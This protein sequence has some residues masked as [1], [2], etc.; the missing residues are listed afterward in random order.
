MPNNKSILLLQDP[1][2]TFFKSLYKEFK[3]MGCGIYH[4]NLGPGDYFYWM[5]Y[6]NTINYKGS[7]QKWSG[8]LESFI[9]KNKITDVIYF[10]DRFPYHSLARDVTEKLGVNAY[11]CESGY[12]RPDWITLERKGMSALSYF[13]SDPEVIIQKAKGLPSI[14]QELKYPHS[15]FI[16]AWHAVTF[17]LLNIFFFW[18]FPKYSQYNYY[19]PIAEYLHMLPRLLRKKKNNIRSNRKLKILIE[20]KEKYYLFP[21]QLQ[22]DSQIH[23]NS[24]FAHI[25]DAIDLAINSFSRNELCDAKLVFKTHPMD[26][27]IEKWHKII[28]DIAKK[29]SILDKIDILDGGDL[30]QMIL[31]A[32]G[33]LTVN[34]T[35]GI[36]ALRLACPTKVLGLSIYDIEGLTYQGHLDDFW[37]H[38]E[39]PDGDLY[40]AFEKLLINY[41]QCKGNLH[42]KVG[43]KLASKKIV[44]RVL[45]GDSNDFDFQPRIKQAKKMGVPINY[46]EEFLLSVSKNLWRSVYKSSI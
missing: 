32:L 12:L 27:G 33:V 7:L 39:K 3:S 19:C 9:L 37:K 17:Y 40:D 2:G 31:N 15:Y 34:S 29:Y 14:T 36:E 24:P 44:D 4:I 11:V 6:R 20:N 41:S 46:Q 38:A 1:T 45:L 5:G 43:K 42:T 23:Y 8:F 25:S 26:C 18:L 30:K 13:P 16:L 28:M 10:K 35:V 22:S 21:L